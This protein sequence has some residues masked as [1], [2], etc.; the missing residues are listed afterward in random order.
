[1][2]SKFDLSSKF[3]RPTFLIKI[4]A[5]IVHI[6]F[7]LILPLFYTWQNAFSIGPKELGLLPATIA[8]SE[9]FVN[10]MFGKLA[11]HYSIPHIAAFGLMLLSI[12]TFATSLST[13]YFQL[14]LSC[15][16]QGFGLA[17]IMPALINITIDLA[18]K[19]RVGREISQLNIS[20]E[21]G[22]FVGIMCGTIFSLGT[23]YSIEKWRIFV[24]SLACVQLLTSFYVLRYLRGLPATKSSKKM[25]WDGFVDLFS[26]S[27]IKSI[28]KSPTLTLLFGAEASLFLAI[29]GSVF[30]IL[31]G[32][33][34]GF[35]VVQMFVLYIFSFASVV[36]GLTVGGRISDHLAAKKPF[37]GRLDFS[38]CSI[39][40]CTIMFYILLVEVAP[41]KKSYPI[42]L[43]ILLLFGIVSR[44]L[45][46]SA[47]VSEIVDPAQKT[48][49]FA[50]FRLI[51]LVML[52]I[53]PA[54]CGWLSESI[55]GFQ[56]IGNVTSEERALLTESNIYALRASLKTLAL[57]G[58]SGCVLI[59]LWLRFTKR[60]PF[61]QNNNVKS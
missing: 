17:L 44:F 16:L 30:L 33:M 45:N 35:S 28:V 23:L 47:M 10:V 6:N 13:H 51:Q 3:V 14:L 55:F 20:C 12:G 54:L 59:Y 1:M 43:G 46:N 58:G 11:T 25:G 49:V 15:M 36:I 27:T 5:V 38:L 24:F 2:A 26:L 31:L 48:H 40:L 42:F 19:E 41:D 53:S 60:S 4:V 52:N 34:I 37:Y 61:S 39:I 56:I 8:L 50:L 7:T 18:A 57:L 32:Q 9:A 22:L 21:L 29:G